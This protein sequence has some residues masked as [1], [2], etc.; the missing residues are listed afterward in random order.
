LIVDPRS[1]VDD[2][3]RFVAEWDGRLPDPP[4]DLYRSLTFLLEE[5]GAADASL[6][7][8]LQ[9]LRR[10]RYGDEA[11]RAV[12]PRLRGEGRVAALRDLYAEAHSHERAAAA[13]GR[14]LLRDLRGEGPAGFEK[15]IRSVRDLFPGQEGARFRRSLLWIAAETW[16]KSFP[17]ASALALKA[18]LGEGRREPELLAKLMRASEKAGDWV[19]AREFALEL[20]R[21]GAW[22]GN[23]LL[24]LRH[25]AQNEP[26]SLE[27]RARLASSYVELLAVGVERIPD[28]RPVLWDSDDDPRRL[29][30][31]CQTELEAIR[32]VGTL[33]EPGTELFPLGPFEAILAFDLAESLREAGNEERAHWLFTEIAG[34]KWAGWGLHA[35]DPFLGEPEEYRCP[36]SL[37]ERAESEVRARIGLL[38]SRGDEARASGLEALLED[39][40]SADLVVDLEW[41]A[42]DT[43][44]DLTLVGPGGDGC[45]HLVELASPDGRP[46][47]KDGTRAA[48]KT[49]ALRRGK[50]G[51]HSVWVEC[52]S[53]I[54]PV[55]ATLTIRLHAGTRRESVATLGVRL[56]ALK[57]KKRVVEVTLD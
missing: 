13:L 11:L 41:R 7:M 28:F 4:G 2:P 55:A 42:P 25:A 15:A 17:G 47:A 49:F 14:A 1:R 44:L 45:P 50:P 5:K 10:T 12:L 23:E 31:L 19:N 22:D 16:E 30:S 21:S 33:V 46:V 9:W 43:A 34:L 51:A 53:G 20:L 35:S 54:V 38:R 29:L 3:V 57:A 6:R 39:A 27:E 36:P 48:R 24:T 18:L 56:E 32:R 37:F 26:W 8:A 52:R 40:V